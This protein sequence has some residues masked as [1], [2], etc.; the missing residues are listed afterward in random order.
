MRPEDLDAVMDLAAQSR[1]SPH[2]TREDFDQMLM[3]APES[4]L[5]AGLWV[6]RDAQSVVGFAVVRWLRGEPV[7]EVENLLVDSRFRR[8]GAGRSLVRACLEWARNVGAGAVRLEVRES[9]APARGLYT[10]LGFV[11]VGRRAAYYSQPAEDAW[12]LEVR[13]APSNKLCGE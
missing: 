4:L 10:Q 9:N 6:A 1:E 11:L 3:P 13:L 12:V 8:Q 2:W 5:L 7:A